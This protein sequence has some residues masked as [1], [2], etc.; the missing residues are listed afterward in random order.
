MLLELRY[1]PDYSY[2]K[3]WLGSEDSILRWQTLASQ[4]CLSVGKRF[5][6]SPSGPLHKA[7]RVSSWCGDWFLSIEWSKRDEGRS[8]N[9]FYGYSLRSHKHLFL[10][11]LIRY[12]GQ[13]YSLWE[14]TIRAW[15]L[16]G[17]NHWEHCGGWL[18][19]L[20]TQQLLMGYLLVSVKD[21]KKYHVWSCLHSP[22][23]LGKNTNSK[24][25]CVLNK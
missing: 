5:N 15:K 4:H 6:S 2:L 10:Q 14:R 16:R 23:S 18:P 7:T 8:W 13:G 20:F 22:Y 19:Q 17:E 12:I 21:K 24:R 11:Y 3:A 9:D 25:Q 1:W